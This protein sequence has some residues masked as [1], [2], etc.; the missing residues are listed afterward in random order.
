MSGPLFRKQKIPSA[1]YMHGRART[2][3]QG[4]DAPTPCLSQGDYFSYD[5]YMIRG[6]NNQNI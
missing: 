4:S 5:A 6:F 1:T 2:R 3:T